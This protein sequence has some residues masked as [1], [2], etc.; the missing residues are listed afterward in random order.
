M[1]YGVY[2]RNDTKSKLIEVSACERNMRVASEY[3]R[4]NNTDVEIIQT[5]KYRLGRLSTL[6]VKE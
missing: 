4:G 1:Y 5:W 2:T 6:V 3:G